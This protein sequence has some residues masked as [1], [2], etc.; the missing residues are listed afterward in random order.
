MFTREKKQ[1]NVRIPTTN[2]Q[3]K[4]FKGIKYTDNRKNDS[5]SIVQRAYEENHD[6][7]LTQLKAVIQ[8]QDAST[9]KRNLFCY[10][11]NMMSKLDRK[12]VVDQVVSEFLLAHPTG[13]PGYCSG[14]KSK[15]R[16]NRGTTDAVATFNAW[17][18][19]KYGKASRGGGR[20][21]KR[22]KKK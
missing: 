10:N 1:K 8:L 19:N 14:N 18:N 13:I 2:I 6:N 3:N 11:T 9:C 21:A 16:P 15:N 17:Y 20:K 4:S 12:G 5:N 7:S 22:G